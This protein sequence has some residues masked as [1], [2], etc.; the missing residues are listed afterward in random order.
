MTRGEKAAGADQRTRRR[1]L[2]AA[3][4][5]LGLVASEA[6]ARATPARADN[7][8]NMILGEGNSATLTTG[9]DASQGGVTAL[10]LITSSA[11]AL[12]AQGSA[13]NFPVIVGHNVGSGIGVQGTTSTGVGV[14]GSSDSHWGVSATSTSDTAMQA[15]SQTGV[16]VVGV[17]ASATGV[18]GQTGATD[19]FALTHDGVRGFTDSGSDSGVRGENAGGGNGVSGTTTSAGTGGR[20][21]VDGTNGGTGPGVRGAG[22]I[23]VIAEATGSGATAL[24][25]R[26]PAVF[27]RSGVLTIAAGSSEATKSGV[28]LTSGSLVLATLQ[29]NLPGIYVT[30]AVPDLANEAF[31]VHLSK[32]VSRPAKV[33]WFVVN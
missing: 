10:Q 7:G 5:A 20:A 19:G 26:G 17:S 22:G 12:Y 29:H 9:L 32:S 3:G 4:A 27:S 21:A 2:A 16:A 13:S 23:G 8:G 25:V 28:P 1:L 24:S 33:A 30:A 6:V 11:E 14:A 18:Y 15:Q 31:T